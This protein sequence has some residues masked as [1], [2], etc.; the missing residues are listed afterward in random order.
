LIFDLIKGVFLKFVDWLIAREVCVSK[1]LFWTAFVVGSSLIFTIVATAVVGHLECR[2][3][4][5]AFG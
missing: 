4:I 2:L 3:V 1:L 5:E